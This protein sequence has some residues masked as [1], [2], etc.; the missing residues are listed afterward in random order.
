MGTPSDGCRIRAAFFH[1]EFSLHA[2][3]RP[4]HPESGRCIP[5]LSILSVTRRGSQRS[6]KK[7]CGE[8]RSHPD[9]SGQAVFETP[10]LWSAVYPDTSRRKQGSKKGGI[11][12]ILCH[13]KILL[14]I[15]SLWRTIIFSHGKSCDLGIFFF[16][17]SQFFLKGFLGRDV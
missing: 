12:Q 3:F 10:L 8:G 16:Q 7:C 9:G 14:T 4:I 11:P 6:W 5:C 1:L 15:F 17:H 13:L 2:A